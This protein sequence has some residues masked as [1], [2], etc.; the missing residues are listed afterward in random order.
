MIL[1]LVDWPPVWTLAHMALAWL[2]ALLWA[3]LNAEAMALGWI[4]VLLA[5]VLMG[6]TAVTLMRAGT[7]VMPGREPTA[8]VTTGPFRLTRNPIYLADLAILAGFSFGVGQPLGALLVWPLKRVLEERF[9]L[10][11][12]A[13]LE[14]HAGEAYLD[15]TRTVARWV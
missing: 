9:V 15:Y 6:W 3:P 13:R 4:V 10:P 2:L 1:K 12:E 11:E 8:L 14:A 5:L 7:T